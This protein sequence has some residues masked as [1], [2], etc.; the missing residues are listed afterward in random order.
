MVRPA[1]RWAP[2]PHSGVAGFPWNQWQLCYGISGNFRVEQVAALAWNRW[3]DSP[4]ISGSFG[5]EYAD[6]EVQ[7][8]LRLIFAKF[9]E[10]GSARAVRTYLAREQL[11]IP[12]RPVRGP[13]PHDTVWNPPRSSTIRRILHNPAYAGAYAY[14]QRVV[15]PA[16]QQPGRRRSGVVPMPLEQWAVC[17]QDVYPAYITWDTYLANRARLQA[18]RNG[19]GQGGPGVPREGKALLQGSPSAVGVGVGCNCATPDR[20]V[21]F[22]SIAAV[23]RP[24]TMVAR[25]ARRFERRGWTK[26]LR[27]SFSRPLSPSV[28]P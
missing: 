19:S 28:S 4:G 9:T 21:I 18:N 23:L 1:S 20:R 25:S 6:E 13:A 16:R 22:R 5:V 11:R 8:R 10:L 14:G 15:D 24:R 26:P 17:L 7:A 3:Q 2:R 27:L 12:S